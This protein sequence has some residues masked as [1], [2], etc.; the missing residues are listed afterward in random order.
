MKTLAGTLLTIAMCAAAPASAAVITSFTSGADSATF[1]PGQSV[2]T[3]AG[4]PW[5]NLTFNWFNAAGAPTAAGSLFLLSQVYTGTPAALSSATAGF[6]GSTS[7]ISGGTWLFAPGITIAPNTQYFLYSN[8][9]ITLSGAA[10][11]TYPGGEAFDAPT[12][13]S[14]FFALTG[15][16][17]NFS[18]AGQVTT[19]TPEPV[20]V[21]LITP[22]LGALWLKRRRFQA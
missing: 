20:T 2:T 11:G 21:L 3:P 9:A 1:V 15:Q 22:V 6:I 17:A 10:V 5:N 18:L 7:N 19:A 4:G 13:A 14:A 8:A 16:D 12:T